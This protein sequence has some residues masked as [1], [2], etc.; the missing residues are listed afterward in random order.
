MITRIRVVVPAHQEQELIG[1]CLTALRAAGTHPLLAELDV[2][3]LI[4]LDAC[5]D[6]TQTSCAAAGIATL[7]INERSVGA[8]RRA[9]LA[10]ALADIADVT[11][12]RN[13]W[14][15]TTDADSQVTCTWLAEQV[16]L[17]NTGSDLVVGVVEVDDWTAHGPGVAARFIAGYHDGPG[18]H[19]HVHGACLGVRAS[20]YLAAGGFAPVQKDED[21]AL[22]AAVA[23]LP[24]T[25]ITR[26]TSVRVRT[27]ARPVSRVRNG[28]AG[29]LRSLAAT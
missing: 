27:S 16:A 26:T 15:A 2:G 11:E 12:Q 19:P 9:G 23:A 14:L 29:H 24:G 17:A 8:A 18:A 22:V 25:R 6:G 28:F 20:T 1:D 13:T 21:H 3:I 7:A 5:T 4:V 10:Y